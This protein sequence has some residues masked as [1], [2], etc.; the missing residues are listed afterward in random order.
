MQFFKYEGLV[1]CET[2]SQEN[3]SRRALHEKTRKI[4]L[5]SDDFNQKLKRKLYFFVTDASEDAITIGVISKDSQHLQ[6]QL[7]E[8]M[9]SV[10]IELKDTSLE[11]ITFGVMRNMLQR[12]NQRDYIPD[13]DEVL[14]QFGLDKLGYRYGRGCRFDEGLIESSSKREIYAAAAQLL[15]NE[16]LIPELDRIYAGKAKNNLTGHPVHYIIQTDDSDIRKKWAGFC[17]RRYMPETGCTAKGTVFW[18]LGQER[19]FQVQSMTAFTKVVL[20]AR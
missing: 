15:S 18:N 4:A 5:K 9:K 2:W 14:E 19:T 3:D 11:E 13:D 20:V 16:T 6:K 8:Y 17:F 12:A 7:E 1:L 10:G